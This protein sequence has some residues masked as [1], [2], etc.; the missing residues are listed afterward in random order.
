[1]SECG[2]QTW[3]LHFHAGLTS[4]FLSVPALA[5][6]LRFLVLFFPLKLC[7]LSF[8]PSSP[9]FIVDLHESDYYNHVSL[10]CF[11]I[12]SAKGVRCYLQF[13]IRQVLGTRSE[14]S[15]SLCQNITRM[16]INPL[17]NIVLPW[18]LVSWASTVILLS[19]QS[20]KSPLGW[21]IKFLLVFNCFYYLRVPKPSTF[22]SRHG[23]ACQQEASASPSLSFP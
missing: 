17:A 19:A 5:A 8:L 9:L 2:L 6:A 3:S 22:L 4:M 18:N 10:G 14:S 21:P 20:L 23:Q 13:S 1:M 7:L 12:S 16:I 15:H 11:K